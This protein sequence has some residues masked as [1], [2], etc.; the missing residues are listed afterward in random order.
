M[1]NY[2]LFLLIILLFIVYFKFINSLDFKLFVFLKLIFFE[3]KIK[4]LNYN[5][6]IINLS[7]NKKFILAKNDKY[8]LTNKGYDFFL[9][10]KDIDYNYSQLFLIVTTILLTIFTLFNV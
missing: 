3:N 9:K 1:K 7:K 8:V 6:F 5:P 10:Y 4:Y 2:Y